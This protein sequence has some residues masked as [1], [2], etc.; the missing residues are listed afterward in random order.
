MLNCSKHLGLGSRYTRRRQ[1]EG[2]AT[3]MKLLRTPDARFEKLPGYSFEPNYVE[4]AADPEQPGEGRLRIHYLDEGPAEGPIVLLMHGEPS[5]SY[6]YRT[7]VGPLVEAG[8]RVIAPDLP[9]FGRSDKPSDPSDYSY[10]RFVQWLGEALFAQLDLRD[11]TLV[12][13]DW[14][15]LIG[16]RLVA[17]NSHRFVRY[18][19]ANT[20][21]PTG[22]QA[23]SEAFLGWQKFSQTTPTFDVGTLIAMATTSDLPPEVVAA[24]D[25]PFPDDSFK[26]GARVFPSLVPTS[27]QDPASQANRD[28]WDVL[29]GLQ[30][31]VLTAFSDED[32]ITSGGEV[33]FHK[34]AP[35]AAGQDHVT[36]AGGGHFLQEDKGP[37][38][39]VAVMRFIAA[40]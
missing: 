35:G 23:P 39:A 27:P 4:V 15:G 33:V 16:L 19:V 9:G 10:L 8:F 21:L 24:Y 30:M 26:A 31:P 28:A 40:N 20:G 38:L 29:S 13:Q 2:E 7:M 5:W 17:E 14:G 1:L 6:L 36:I 37:E 3:I 12:C 11:I 22:D 18:V 25:A 34:L 32:A